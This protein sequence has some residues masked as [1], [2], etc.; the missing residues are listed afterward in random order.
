MMTVLRWEDPGSI[1]THEVLY[2][3][4]TLLLR[5]DAP[6]VTTWI[7]T[8]PSATQRWG[9]GEAGE[10]GPAALARIVREASAERRVWIALTPTVLRSVLQQA[11]HAL[12][13]AV[14]AAFHPR[15]VHSKVGQRKPGVKR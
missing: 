10:L 7:A 3:G 13:V 8:A 1:S 2:P 6:V 4:S 15:T 9:V 14:V 11:T 5:S 12:V